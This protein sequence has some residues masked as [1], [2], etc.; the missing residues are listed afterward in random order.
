MNIHLIIKKQEKLI[1]LT[2]VIL[3]ILT[4]IYQLI[5]RL[6]SFVGNFC[7]NVFGEEEAFYLPAGKYTIKRLDVGEGGIKDKNLDEDKKKDFLFKSAYVIRNEDSFELYSFFHL[8]SGLSFILSSDSVLEIK[9]GEHKK[10][11]VVLIYDRIQ[12]EKYEKIGEI[13][14]IV[15]GGE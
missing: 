2:A 6:F 12:R 14:Y 8:E 3:L 4:L 10:L 1:S 5:L 9:K 7:Y 15:L 13:G 11:R